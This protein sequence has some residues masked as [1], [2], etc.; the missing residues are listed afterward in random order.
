MAERSSDVT[1]HDLAGRLGLSTTTVW[2]ALNDQSRISDKTR[3]RVKDEARALNYRPSL[4]AR[5]LSSGKTQT[6]G[7]VVPSVANPTFAGLVQAVEDVAFLRGYNVLLCNTGF[8]LARERKQVELLVR[9][10]VE[11]V[12]VVPYFK[13]SAQENAHLHGLAGQGVPL[14]SMHHRMP[15]MR[16]PE[17]VPDNV[18]AAYDATMHLIQLGHKRLAFIHTGLFDWMLPVYERYE[19]FCKAVRESGLG[20]PRDAQVGAHDPKTPAPGMLANVQAGLVK[21]LVTGKGAPT[22]LFAPSD[23]LAARVMQQVQSLGLVV[24]DDVAIAGFDD[25]P[26]ASLTTPGITSVRPALAKIGTRSGERLFEAI[27]GAG[28]KSDRVECLACE[29]HIRGST[30]P[31]SK[32]TKTSDMTESKGIK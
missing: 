1:I 28:D 26:I 14:V 2:R 17:I 19:G 25:S 29:L 30:A 31:G 10:Q 21:T 24:P 5:A 4:V 20:E 23:L 9:R 6:L 15:D 27:D 3:Q 22:A 18:Q 8:D 11:G 7:L 13:R 32:N 16:L 12:V